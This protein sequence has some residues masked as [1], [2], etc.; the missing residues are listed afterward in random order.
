MKLFSLFVFGIVLMATA[1]CNNTGKD[2]NSTASTRT[3]T[4]P[5]YFGKFEDNKI[6]SGDFP[7]GKLIGRDEALKLIMNFRKE[8]DT[9]EYPI[10]TEKD[11]NLR[12]FYISRTAFDTLLKDA[13][14]TGIMAYFAKHPKAPQKVYTIVFIPTRYN[15]GARRTTDD[16]KEK[17]GAWEEIDPCPKICGGS[18][19]NP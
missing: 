6:V 8:I 10:K 14:Y 12:G 7:G 15:V 4:S 1:S 9:V 18:G 17:D 5:V 13:S 19:D 3:D 2:G 11:Q 16:L